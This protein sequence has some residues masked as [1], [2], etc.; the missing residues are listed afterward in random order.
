MPKDNIESEIKISEIQFKNLTYV[1]IV[2]TTL[3][4]ILIPNSRIFCI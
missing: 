3:S 2:M 4:A 1:I